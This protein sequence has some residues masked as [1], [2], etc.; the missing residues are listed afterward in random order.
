MTSTSGLYSKYIRNHPT[1]APKVAPVAE[2]RDVSQIEATAQQWKTVSQQWLEWLKQGSNTTPSTVPLIPTAGL[3]SKN[4]NTNGNKNGSKKDFLSWSQSSPFQLNIGSPKD[5]DTHFFSKISTVFMKQSGT[6][7]NELKQW[8]RLNQLIPPS[9]TASSVL[10]NQIVN[11]WEGESRNLKAVR[12]QMINIQQNIW[13]IFSTLTQLMAQ[14]DAVRFQTDLQTWKQSPDLKNTLQS[15]V[16]VP[17]L[18]GSEGIGLRGD[19]VDSFQSYLSQFSQ[20]LQQFG[21]TTPDY[22]YYR[23]GQYIPS[24]G[25]PQQSYY[26]PQRNQSQLQREK[27]Q[28]ESGMKQQKDLFTQI[29]SLY[30]GLILSWWL[31]EMQLDLCLAVRF[32]A[33]FCEVCAKQE[34]PWKFVYAWNASQWKQRYEVFQS[35]SLTFL[36][37]DTFNRAF[38]EGYKTIQGQSW[39][40]LSQYSPASQNTNGKGNGNANKNRVV[41]RQVA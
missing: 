21:S 31:V 40:N 25:L 12:I 32:W 10:L 33:A 3:K 2:N 11:T 19:Q 1:V 13:K 38:T 4:G 29:I 27:A 24:Y 37:T 18:V 9:K 14:T 7:L 15:S 16:Q 22:G 6:I 39:R 28:L 23:G 26:I 35:L 34:T 8:E 17:Q 20:F 30:P 5:L 41:N 36:H